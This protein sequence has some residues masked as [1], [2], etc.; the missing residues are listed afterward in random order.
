MVTGQGSPHHVYN[1][2]WVINNLMSGKIANITSMMGTISDAFPTLYF[3]LCDLVGDTWDPSDQE[4]FPGYGCHNPGGRIGTQSKQFYVCPSHKRKKNCGGPADGFC[5]KWGCE[6]T[7]NVYWSPSSNW[8]Y[9]TL[10]RGKTPHGSACYDSSKGSRK[11][12]TPGGKC[13]PLV[14]TFTPAGKRATWD[15]SQAWGLRLYRTGHDPI[16]MFSLTRHILTVEPRLPLGPNPVLPD[17]KAPLLKLREPFPEKGPRPQTNGHNLTS[18]LPPDTSNFTPS[19]TRAAQGISTKMD[20]APRPGTGDRLLGLIQG[21]FTAL[22]HSD[23]NKTQECWLCLLSRPPYYEGVAIQDNYTSHTTPPWRCTSL[24]QHRLTL[25]E[26]SGQGVCIGKV[27]RTHQRLCNKTISIEANT[28]TQYLAGPN[29]TYWACS[30]GL[31]PC[32]STGVLNTSIDFCVLIELWP[33]IIYHPPEYFYSHSQSKDVTRSRREPISLTLALLLGGLTVGG[34]TAGIGTG[35]SALQQTSH[36]KQL[37]QAMH[38]D[39]QALEESVTAL[40]KSLTS[41]SEVVLQN[42]RGLDIIFLQQGGLCAALKEE[43]CFYADHT[44]VVRDSMAKLRERLKQRQ[45]LFESQ[46]GWFESWYNKSPWLSTLVSTIMGPLIILLLI[47]VLGPC[48]L[49]RLVQ[50]IKDRLTVIQAMV[51]T[52]Q[53]HQL[54]QIDPDTIELTNGRFHS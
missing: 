23:P 8:D 28:E 21:A 38:M 22:N 27:P 24:P 15:G 36:F 9:I 17:Q 30:T 54:G 18:P 16:T 51:L 19:L 31:T 49:N 43:C 4:P 14:L 34:I 3:D 12:S 1:V 20:Q 42:R 50:F 41:L 5:A 2:T 39:I 37:Q 25:S 46:Q 6:T 52:Q 29:G 45:Q 10:R 26:V 47:L 11:G 53:Y 48:I 40:E 33:T 13:N 35:V 32:I 7:G 44:G